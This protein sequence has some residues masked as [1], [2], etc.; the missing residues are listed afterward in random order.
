VR[1]L[2]YLYI[3]CFSLYITFDSYIFTYKHF[4][5]LILIYKLYKSTSIYKVRKMLIYSLYIVYISIY[6]K[7]VGL[8]DH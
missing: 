3:G 5:F 4:L 6:N 2:I 7:K 1:F 8:D